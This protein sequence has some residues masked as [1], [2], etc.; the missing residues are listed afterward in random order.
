MLAVGSDD[1][2]TNAGGKVEIH[3]LNTNTRYN[4]FAKQGNATASNYKHSL[5]N[6]KATTFCRVLTA[7]SFPV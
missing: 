1:P 3:V 7:C 6:R 4:I 5:Q 2:S